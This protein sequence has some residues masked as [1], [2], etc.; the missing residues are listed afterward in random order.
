[1]YDE[2]EAVVEGATADVDGGRDVYV[3]LGTTVVALDVAVRRHSCIAV[4]PPPP[5]R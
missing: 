2:V 5:R 1:M 3:L 4:P